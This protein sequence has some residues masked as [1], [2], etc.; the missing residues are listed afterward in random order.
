MFGYFRDGVN[1]RGEEYGATSRAARAAERAAENSED[2]L[3]LELADASGDRY[4]AARRIT[5]RRVAQQRRRDAVHLIDLVLSILFVAAVAVFML[6]PYKSAV[7]HDARP[8]VSQVPFDTNAPVRAA[9][10]SAIM[11]SVDRARARGD[12]DPNNP[13]IVY[14]SNSDFD[15][16]SA[17]DNR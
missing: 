15:N 9:Q 13:N 10:S 6:S 7:T 11:E 16:I 3:D 8:G 14:L 17:M 12:V 5:R 2:M 4:S 1:P